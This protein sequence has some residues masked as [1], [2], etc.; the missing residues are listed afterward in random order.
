[1]AST[2]YKAGETVITSPHTFPVGTTTVE[3]T[4]TDLHGNSDTGTF[5]VTVN[6]TQPPVISAPADVTQAN[7]AGQCSAV[8]TYTAPVGTDNC[9]GATTLQTAGLPSGSAFPVGSTLNS[10]EVT[11][12][13]GNKTS[14]SFSV[15]VEDRTLPAITTQPVS[16]TNQVGTAAS[17]S[18]T[19]S[20]CT[21]LSF[22]WYL[23]AFSFRARPPLRS[24][25]RQ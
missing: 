25:S 12:A 3:V 10:F 2:L 20:A 13:S 16:C 18:I 21:A 8:V 9:A 4:V 14:C 5:T 23:K 17:F 19:A 1:M 22:Q 6:D 7:D 11:D 24:I 15:T